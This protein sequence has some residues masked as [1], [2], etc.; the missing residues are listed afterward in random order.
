MTSIHMHC[1]NIFMTAHLVDVLHI[2]AVAWRSLYFC[3]VHES[4]VHEYYIAHTH[5]QLINQIAM[6]ACT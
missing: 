5:V 4:R 1:C 3:A 6:V 2:H